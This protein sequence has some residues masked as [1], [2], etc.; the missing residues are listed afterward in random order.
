MFDP[1]S[2]DKNGDSRAATLV[3]SLSVFLWACGGIKDTLPDSG[4]SC[5]TQD[6]RR[7]PVGAVFSDGCGC[8]T[9][10]SSGWSCYGGNVCTRFVDGGIQSLMSIPACQSDD[11]CSKMIDLGAVC[12]FDQGCIPG[13]GRCVRNPSSVCA[14]YASDIAHDYCGCDGQTFHVGASGAKNY[15]DHPYAHLGPCP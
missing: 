2:R 3:L 11:D 9:C 12:V 14:A 8:C 1:S 4:A 5:S 13:Q 7:F 6:R 10:A 15:P